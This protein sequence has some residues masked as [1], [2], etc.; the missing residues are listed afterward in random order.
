[1]LNVLLLALSCAIGVA[2]PVWGLGLYLLFEHTLFWLGDKYT[3]VLLPVGSMSSADVLP[4]AILVGA[5]AVQRR[6]NAVDCGR[7]LVETAR[8]KLI[9]AILPC[10]S[11]VLGCFVI[12]ALDT[13]SRV[14]IGEFFRNLLNFVVP[15]ALAPAMW[16]LRQD[17]RTMRRLLIAAAV[18]TSSIH[19]IL[20]GLN[21]RS[22]FPAAYYGRDLW[23]TEI[24]QKGLL[25]AG[26]FIRFY[27]AGLYLMLPVAVMLFTESLLAPPMWARR[28]FALAAIMFAGIWISFMRSAQVAVVFGMIAAMAVA[29]FAGPSLARVLAR[30][31]ITSAV[32]VLSVTALFVA[33]PNAVDYF[34]RRLVSAQSEA[35]GLFDPAT[36]RGANN[37]AALKALEESPLVGDGGN[38]LSNARI[39][40]PE[41]MHDVHSFLQIAVFGG[42]PALLLLI[43]GLAN[44]LASTFQIVQR[45][46][47]NPG[48][49]EMTAALATA[50]ITYLFF[51]SLGYTSLLINR[52][53]AVL[54]MLVGLLAAELSTAFSSSD[55]LFLPDRLLG[56]AS[57]HLPTPHHKG[58]NE[59]SVVLC[60]SAAGPR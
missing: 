19:L 8:R 41:A 13:H 12:S 28:A 51:S 44:L 10:I 43:G 16:I 52:G 25:H 53:G 58:Q 47:H 22:F 46:R 14:P 37:L 57:V 27:P 45:T 60:R 48:A 11:W 4:V 26:G 7:P 1:M 30:F 20:M 59:H 17:S 31:L 35:T 49:A 56:V 36:I 54:S 33:N 34:N 24:Q 23:S 29:I 6:R 42:T 21:L 3:V 55:A 50:V 38:Y 5:L 18:A 39:A 15:W 9:L 2:R 32:L 40:N